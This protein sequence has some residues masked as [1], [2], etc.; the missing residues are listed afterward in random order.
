VGIKTTTVKEDFI[1]Y[2]DAGHGIRQGF[3]DKD[4]ILNFSV[5]NY[6]DADE[7]LFNYL[8]SKSTTNQE[9][10]KDQTLE[11]M[12]DKERTLVNED[13]RLKAVLDIQ[14]YLAEKLYYVS[15]VGT[16]QWVGVQSRVQNYNYSNSLGKATESY[17]KL[18]LKT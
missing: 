16:Y 11:A 15:S 7:W 9:H 18:W 1:A 6:S 10:L 12:V 2:I 5:A 4:I 17:A 14:K 8:H 3:F 13:E